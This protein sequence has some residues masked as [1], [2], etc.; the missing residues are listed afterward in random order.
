[1]QR[2]QD[3]FIR[4]PAAGTVLF[5]AIL[6]TSATF[7]AAQET[8]A[9]NAITI[10]VKLSQRLASDNI[11]AGDRFAFVTTQAVTVGDVTIPSG[12]PGHGTVTV[13]RKASWDRGGEIQLQV[14]S[15]DLPDGR[16]IPVT[17][18]HGPRAEGHSVVS[19]AVKTAENAKP[20]AAIPAALVPLELP[21]RGIIM[22]GS[23][24]HVLKGHNVVFD[25]GTPFSVVATAG[26]GAPPSQPPM[27]ATPQPSAS[28]AP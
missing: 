8:N 1:M 20:D 13:A 21:V 27:Q 10:P 23:A 18:A 17:A 24:L 2:L 12:T 26:P 5:A 14:Q 11:K 28:E 6:F 22:L 19:D 15:V 25:S 16:T 7:V 3:S 4:G 9:S